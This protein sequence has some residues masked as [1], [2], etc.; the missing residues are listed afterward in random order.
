M[1]VVIDF[2][3]HAWPRKAIYEGWLGQLR[4]QGRRWWKPVSSSMH[5]MQ[6]FVRHLP[7]PARRRL[8]ELGSLTPIPGLL[9]EST[10]GDLIHAMQK[11]GVDRAVLIA[12]PPFISNDFVI[13]ACRTYP[14]LV[15]VV[16]ITRDTLRPAVTLKAMVKRGAK[17]LK[18]H[19]AA[20]GEGPDSPRYNLLLKTAA[21]LNLPVILHTGCIHS[22]VLYKQP[23][24]GNAELFKPWFKEFRELRFIL[25]HMNYHEPE[26]AFDLAEEHFNL[27]M[28][29]SWQPAEVI[30][31][32]VRRIGADRVLFGTDWPYVGGNLAVGLGRIRECL[33]AG[34]LNQD[35]ARAILGENAAKLLGIDLHAA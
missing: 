3:V 21:E 2:H 19:T 8:D 15:P 33:E 1:P 13:E 7:E 22:H 32:A 11:S 5:S 24:L 9:L 28:D 17:A 31:E 29:T 35:Q 14:E 4:K 18:I 25:A 30:G 23:Q 20:D 10:I 27:Y 16:N 34:T 6:T 26:I 12:H